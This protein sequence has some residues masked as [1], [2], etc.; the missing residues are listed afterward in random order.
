[1]FSR[2]MKG[3]SYLEYPAVGALAGLGVGSGVADTVSRYKKGDESGASLSALGTALSA[4]Q[5]FL[6]GLAGLSAGSGA[7][8]IPLYQAAGDRLKHLERHP[9]DYRLAPNDYDA[10]GNPTGYAP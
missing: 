1:M 8:A 9:E 5:P 6:G 10:L 3:L 7:L 4:A 2:A